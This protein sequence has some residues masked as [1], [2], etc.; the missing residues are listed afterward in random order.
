MDMDRLAVDNCSTRDR[1]TIRDTAL[2]Q[3]R[4]RGDRSK[5]SN[6]ASDFAVYAPHYSVGRVTEFGSSL[7]NHIEHGLEVRRRASDHPEDVAGGGLAFE[8]LV[9]LAPKLLVLAD[10]LCLLK[11]GASRL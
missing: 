2:A 11:G 7:G 8:Q 3:G 1:A 4:R 10:Q 5:V 9:A 6:V